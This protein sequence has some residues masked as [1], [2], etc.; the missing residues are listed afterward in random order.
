MPDSKNSHGTTPT[1]NGLGTFAGVFTPSILTILGIILF[2]RLGFVVGSAGLGR[3]LLIIGL[4][5]AIALLTTISLSA[6]A[7][8]IKVKGGGDYYLIS[9]TLGVEFGGAIGIVLFLADSVSIAFYAVGFAE[10]LNAI[11]PFAVKLSVPVI[12]ALAVAFLFVFAWLGAD[13]ATRLQYLIMSVVAAALLSFFYGGYLHWDVSLVSQNWSGSGTDLGFWVLFAIFFPAITGF[14]QGVN[15]SGDLRD[16]GKSLP[17]GTIAAVALSLVIYFGAAFIFAGTLPGSI[18]LS[19]YHSM[20]RVA[21]LG[22][23][24]DAGLIAG[25]LSSAMAS[26][27]GAPRILQSLSSDRI[28]PFLMPFAK[29]VGPSA[30]PR[31]AVLLSGA[32]ALVT[33][34]LGNLNFIASVVSM[35]FLI[36]YGLLNYATFYEARAASPSFRPRFR[37]FPAR[38]SFVGALGALG[39]M[40]AIDPP[41]SGVAVAVLF[42]IHQYLKRTAGPARWADSRRSYYFQLVRENLIAI[43]HEAEHPRDWRPC[44][45]AF[46]DDPSR[47]ERL[48]R[49]ASW[50]EGGSGLTTAVQLI[51][52]D[53]EKA[54]QLRAKAE[55]EL[56]SYIA[57]RELAAFSRVVV[58]PDFR[59]GV[60]TLIQSFGVGNIRANMVLLNRVDQIHE[61]EENEAQ[62]RYGRELQEA[63]RV[64]CNVI[65]FDAEEEEW[66][67]LESLP[68]SDLRIDVWWWGER[69]SYLMLLLAYLMTRSER[70]SGAKIKLLVPSSM[71]AAEKSLERV[72]HVLE[73]VR[74]DAEAEVVYDVDADLVVDR[75]EAAGLV[76]FPLR[77]RE[78]H[79]LTPLGDEV[80]IKNLVK[81]LP[82]VALTLAA[83]DIDLSAGP[84]EGQI[85]ELTAALDAAKDAETQATEAEEEALRLAKEA[86]QKLQEWETERSAGDADNSKEEFA[87]ALREAQLQARA[88]AQRA[89]EARAQANATASAAKNLGMEAPQKK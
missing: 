6:V 48:L 20:K 49:F 78:L 67:R 47:C 15:M 41:A 61:L 68:A 81:R 79:L 64:R 50:I 30:N 17:R 23:L 38:M 34:S 43:G 11:L 29:G 26:F 45:L 88:A 60:E 72:R 44:I 12:A 77:F 9:R 55:D 89:A 31:R 46:C 14:T 28:F 19:D 65:V 33:I 57:D 25:T 37:F 86:E 53:D 18:L 63:I 54:F 70:W 13:W 8:N 7:T 85:A 36:T 22:W 52:G 73:E 35:F 32:I 83:E 62:I 51:E 4:S 71:E 42:A 56:R 5:G 21:T 10:A 1:R 80:G 74:I 16:A 58:A 76:F 3:A 87:T 82:I 2:L 59:A 27:L 84:D 75:S 24:I 40:I 69:T 66:S 39:A